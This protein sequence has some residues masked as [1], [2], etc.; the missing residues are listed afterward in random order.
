MYSLF[1]SS[2]L[3]ALNSESMSALAVLDASVNAFSRAIRE[4]S[5]LSNATAFDGKW[6]VKFVYIFKGYTAHKPSLLIT[7]FDQI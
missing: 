5:E 7:Y 6:E 3:A 4:L 1:S 2:E